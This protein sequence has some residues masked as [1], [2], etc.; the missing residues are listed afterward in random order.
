LY[1][2]LAEHFGEGQVFK[3]VDSIELGDDFVEVITTA[4]G[5]CDVLLALIGDRWLSITDEDGRRRLDSPD[6]FVR[7]EIEAALARKV[8]VIPILVEGATMPRADELPPTL[9]E[10][11]RRQ[12]LELS[13]SRF[14]VDTS[15]LLKVLDKVLAEV[16]ALDGA[17]SVSAPWQ[18]PEPS[19]TEVQRVPERRDQ[20]RLTPGRGPPRPVGVSPGGPERPSDSTK[21]QD[22]KRRRLS[23][24]VRVLGGVGVGVVLIALLIALVANSHTTPPQ[25]GGVV[26]SGAVV[27]RDDFSGPGFGW[28]D[29]GAK[30]AGGHYANGAYQIHLAPVP[31]GSALGRGPFKEG[32]LY[33]SAP[34]NLRIDV[35]G[36][37]LAGGQ[38]TGY[39][40]LCRANMDLHSLRSGYAFIMGDG[41]ISIAKYL[42][43]APWFQTLPRT[44]A[45]TPAVD[46]NA[47]NQLQ[48]T[49]NSAEGQR[50]VH[51][52]FSVNGRVVAEAIDKKDPF[53]AGTVGLMAWTGENAKTAVDAEFDDFVVTQL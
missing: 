36:R 40:I 8:R 26:T 31:D 10:L 50:A 30:R 28:E 41:F 29:A 48:A 38:D 15:Q 7:L 43:H 22:K 11:V 24:R 52:A 35:T 45:G 12:A 5:S 19:G 18:A 2:R 23:T 14:A 6:D 27:F 25:T 4:V 49:C 16:G 53:S 33:P 46:V 51:L 32:R 20:A 17:A 34:R 47:T 3:D 37:R 13:P 42:D 21:P 9:V 39:G 44:A 1:D